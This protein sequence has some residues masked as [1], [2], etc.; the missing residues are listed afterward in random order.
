[1]STRRKTTARPL[2]TFETNSGKRVMI[3]YATTSGCARSAKYDV[4]V[5]NGLSKAGLFAEEIMRW[6][7]E[8]LT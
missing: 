1:M 3:D 4:F 2:I 5:D 7:V 8:E 6:I